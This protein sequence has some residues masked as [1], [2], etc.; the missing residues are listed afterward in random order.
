MKLWC[1]QPESGI[2]IGGYRVIKIEEGKNRATIYIDEKLNRPI[3]LR[4]NAIARFLLL[5]MKEFK[6]KDIASSMEMEVYLTSVE[7]EGTIALAS[8]A[9]IGKKAFEC[10]DYVPNVDEGVNLGVCEL[11]DQ[12]IEDWEMAENPESIFNDGDAESPEG[13][14]VL[15][16]SIAEI[17]DGDWLD[18]QIEK[19][20]PEDK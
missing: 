16:R 10:H 12:I 15:D 13:G 17:E 20:P 4:M 11:V 5:K 14:G 9:F 3:G 19:K 18:R 7:E 8:Y 2:V 6:R 1:W